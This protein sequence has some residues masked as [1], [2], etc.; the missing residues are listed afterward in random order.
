MGFLDTL[1][2]ALLGSREP[3]YAIVD[4]ETT[5]LSKR[6][7]IIEL[8]VVI[9]D[10]RFR[11]VSR[12]GTLINPERQ[13]PNSHIHGVTDQMVATAP[14]FRE[15]CTE[16]ARQI[17]GLILMAHNANYDGKMLVA[18][19]DRVSRDLDG[20][21]FFPF[22]DT[23]ALAKQLTTGPYKLATLAKKCGVYNPHA[24]AAVDDAATTAA[25][26]RKLFGVNVA[27][28]TKQIQS[29]GQVFDG[30]DVFT[31]ELPAGYIA[32]R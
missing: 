24:H 21:V 18:E 32:T 14:T 4:T 20:D 5:G 17:D 27:T 11:E 3:I 25:V 31:W 8:G 22:V 23:I 28:A 16:F 9:V 26:L 2:K 12:W 1:T 15:I 10:E 19:F 30:A 7:R 6:D 13:I 29:Q